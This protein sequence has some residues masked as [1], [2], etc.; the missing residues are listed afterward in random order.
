MIPTVEHRYRTPLMDSGRWQHYR[1]RDSDIIISTPYKCGTTWTQWICALLIFGGDRLPAPLAQISPWLDQNVYPIDEVIARFE[2]QTHRRFIK[3]HT[4]LSALPYFPKVTYLVCG[5]DPRDVFFSMENHY[6]NI[7]MEKLLPLIS[8]VSGLTEA[9]PVLPDDVNARF[10]LWLTQGTV[11]WESDGYPFWSV[12]YH[13]Q[14]FWRFRQLPNIHFIH[15]ADLKRDL[16]GEMR[17][18]ALLLDIVVP[19]RDWSRMVDA[20]RFESMKERHEDL[21]P[22]VNQGFWRDAAKFFNKGVHG[23]WQGVLDD[24]SLETYEEV[25]RA[26]L[27]PTLAAWI[28]HL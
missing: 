20:A 4:P 19:E 28:D 16:E 12:F 13:L 26:R 24:A 1:P 11:P 27:E 21:A 18:I 2:A 14:S 15:Y 6:A 8:S 25:K 7:D 10:H 3:S 5:R 23:Q 9:P 17:R 22:N